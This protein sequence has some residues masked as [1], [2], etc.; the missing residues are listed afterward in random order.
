[1]VPIKFIFSY[2]LFFHILISVSVIVIIESRHIQECVRIKQ[3][4]NGIF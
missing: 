1:M 2:C 3:K 4:T